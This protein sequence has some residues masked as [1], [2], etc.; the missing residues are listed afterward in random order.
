MTATIKQS[1]NSKKRSSK[2]RRSLTKQHIREQ[3]AP[4]K[5]KIRFRISKR[6]NIQGGVQK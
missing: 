4:A 3:T 6:F 2:R 5:Q 1:N